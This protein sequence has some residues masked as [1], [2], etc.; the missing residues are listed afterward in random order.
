VKVPSPTGIKEVARQVSI[1]T[2]SNVFNRPELVAPAVPLS[3]VAQPREQLGR[4]ATEL[5]FGEINDGPTHR[6]RQVLFEPE[7]VV[8]E[9][10]VDRS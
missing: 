10:T 5:L 3:S 9:S 4:T 2:V 7:L 1:A 6:H 8:R